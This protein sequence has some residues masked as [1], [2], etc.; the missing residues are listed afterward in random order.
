MK[1]LGADGEMSEVAIGDVDLDN[2]D[3]LPAKGGK[4]PKKG[5]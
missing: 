1:V 5:N 2:F 3:D 4:T